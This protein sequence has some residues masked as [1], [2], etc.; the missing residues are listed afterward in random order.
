MLLGEI[1]FLQ[2]KAVAENCPKVPC[3]FQTN[4]FSA[5]SAISAGVLP[6]RPGGPVVVDQWPFQTVLD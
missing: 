4:P 2:T 6:I 3:I 5:P 1:H